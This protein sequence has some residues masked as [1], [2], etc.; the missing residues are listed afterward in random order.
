[1]IFD[2]L[3]LVAGDRILTNPVAHQYIRHAPDVRFL[4]QHGQPQGVVVALANVGHLE[5]THDAYVVHDGG[6]AN[7]T[8][9]QQ[10]VVV[11][12]G[13]RLDHAAKTLAVFSDLF[14][15]RAGKGTAVFRH[16]RQLTLQLFRHPKVIAVTKGDVFAPGPLHGHSSGHSGAGIGFQTGI[17]DPRILRRQR[18]DDRL[19]VILRTVVHDLDL[20]VAVGLCLDGCNC[21]RNE[22][23]T[24]IRRH[25]DRHKSFNHTSYPLKSFFLPG[26]SLFPARRGLS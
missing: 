18:I 3:Q 22:F 13:D 2:E 5:L 23:A 16:E 21:F 10:A 7:G 15:R 1:M 25:D 9:Q 14:I 4:F 8:I 19:G 20:P 11:G 24:V 26:N 17:V 12:L 6:I